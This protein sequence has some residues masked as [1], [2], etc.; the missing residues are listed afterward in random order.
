[1][2]TIA[3]VLK[4]ENSLT[5][6]DIYVMDMAWLARHP[7]CVRQRHL[8][9]EALLATVYYLRQKNYD[10]SLK[11]TGMLIDLPEREIGLLLNDFQF[12]IARFN[13]SYW[14]LCRNNW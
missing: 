6:Y 4:A 11:I 10:L 7:V 5:P 8:I 12:L 3:Y 13:E 1:M 14:A 2:A 9:G